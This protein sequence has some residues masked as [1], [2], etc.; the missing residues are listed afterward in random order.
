MAQSDA[1]NATMLRFQTAIVRAQQL[2]AAAL[3]TK[4]DSWISDQIVR[5]QQL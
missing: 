4:P 2:L 3:K 1:K 5:E